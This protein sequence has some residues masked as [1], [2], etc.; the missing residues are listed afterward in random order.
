MRDR[1]SALALVPRASTP[2]ELVQMAREDA[3]VWEPV[4]KASGFS[5]E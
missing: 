4:I 1:L 3:A 5:V 2:E